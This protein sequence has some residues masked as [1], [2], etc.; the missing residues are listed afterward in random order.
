VPTLFVVIPVFEEPDTLEPCVRRAASSPLPEGWVRKLLLVDDASSRATAEVADRLA[1][2]HAGTG[3]PLELLRHT[4]NRGKGAA[5]RTGFDRALM[6]ATDD[7]AVLTQ[8]GDLE[9]D[10]ADWA[11]LLASLPP[12]PMSAVIGDRWAHAH[13]GSLWRRL[14]TMVNRALTSLSNLLTGLQ[15]NDMECGSKLL[16]VPLL[17][18]IRPWLSEDRFGVEPQMVAALSRVQARVTQAP[19]TYDPRDRARGKKIGPVDGLRAVWVIL[20]ERLRRTPPRK[21]R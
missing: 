11:G 4:A 18:A 10:P 1:R 16:R 6:L 7:D 3:G 8:D 14:H 19:V 15:V 9:Y 17:R 13:D 12:G 20:R 2:E 21:P 5:L